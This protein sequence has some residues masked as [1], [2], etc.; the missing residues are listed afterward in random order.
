MGQAP[1]RKS[2]DLQWF[3]DAKFGMFIHWG[4]YS[5]LAGTYKGKNYYGSG[6]WIMYQ[7]QI[8]AAEYATIASRFNPVDFNAGA[9]AQLA[10]DA[11]IRYMVITAKHH[12]GFSM[13]DS[14]VSDFNIVKATPY[15]KDPMKALAAANRKRGIQFGFYYSQYLDW[16]E[17]NG[18]GNDWDFVDS[19]KKTL[20][21]YYQKSIPQLK[22]LM[23]NYGPLGIIWFDQPGGLTRAQTQSMLDTLR[24]LQPNTL[25]SSRVGEGLGD[26]TDFGDSEVPPL[27]VEGPWESVYTHNDSWG[28]IRHDMNFKSSREIIRLLAN[29]AS[30]GGNL[31]LNVGPDGRGRI[32]Y[33]SQQYL[34]ETG[35]WLK[36]FGTAIYGTTYGA[37]PPQPW[38][39]TTS[40]PGKIFL[41]V[42][43]RPAK[44]R[45]LVPDF[46]AR[47]KSVYQLDTKRPVAFTKKGNDLVVQVP[48]LSD[49][50]NTVFVVDYDG[51]LPPFDLK[52]PITVDEQYPVNTCAAVFAQLS[53]AAKHENITFSHYFGDWKNA[54]C[55]TG[56]AQ[57]EDQA[58][59]TIRVTGKSDYKLVLEYACNAASSNQ[60]GVVEVNGQPYAFRTLHTGEYSI[61]EPL[62]FIQHPVAAIS[63]D[64][65]GVYRITIRPMKNGKSLF[66]LKNL[67]LV[68]LSTPHN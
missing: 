45:L 47:V 41:H 11:G 50:N 65:P 3:R 63:F 58:S 7:A 34:L 17:P 32:P 36:K 13:Y 66:S 27:P 6:E 8:P 39:V 35:A 25:F 59:F 12:E 57:P 23:S 29:I 5:E 51:Q 2:P 61:Y 14:K 4:L 53:G 33:F 10:K 49:P 18:G 22:E 54:N 24:A 48:Q 60:E 46:A 40:K 38:G 67:L 43:E 20:D 19:T 30:K 64:H 62:L 52:R 31:M 44:G 21:Y 55:I 15:K 68:P 42:L 37:I 16:H 26:Y 56:L 1:Q 9:W 28:Y